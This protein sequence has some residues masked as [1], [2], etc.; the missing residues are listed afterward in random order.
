MP[1]AHSYAAASRSRAGR[2]GRR[3]APMPPLSRHGTMPR[4]ADSSNPA[5]CPMRWRT[6]TATSTRSTPSACGTITGYYE[7]LLRGS[8]KQSSQYRFP[9][10]GV[11]DDLL[12]VDLGEVYPEIKNLR[13]HSI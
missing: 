7:P 4:C 1:S 5:S 10:L 11:P 3:Y 13:L 2:N 8:R 9:V 6:P 12:I